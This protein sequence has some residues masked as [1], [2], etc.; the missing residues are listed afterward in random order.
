MHVIVLLISSPAQT[1][2]E[3][4]SNVVTTNPVTNVDFF[5]SILP[6]TCPGCKTSEWS[7]GNRIP[8]LASASV[9]VGISSLHLFKS[10]WTVPLLIHCVSRIATCPVDQQ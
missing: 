6:T 4:K 7:S 2:P 5:D 9:S 8:G 3:C 1:V 10:H